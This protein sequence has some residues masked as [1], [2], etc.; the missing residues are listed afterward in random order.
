MCVMELQPV[1]SGGRPTGEPM[2]EAAFI[3]HGDLMNQ[4]NPIHCLDK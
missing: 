1:P 2:H 4:S 3:E